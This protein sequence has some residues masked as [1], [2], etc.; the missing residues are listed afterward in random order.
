MQMGTAEILSRRLDEIERIKDDLE[1]KQGELV[2]EMGALDDRLLA[3]TGEFDQIIA[4]AATWIEFG[5]YL[6]HVA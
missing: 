2:S 3:L 6:R 1:A 4:K 5:G